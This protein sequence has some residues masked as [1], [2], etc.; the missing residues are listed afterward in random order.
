MFTDK[1]LKEF[2]PRSL[3]RIKKFCSLIYPNQIQDN[4]PNG[5]GPEIDMTHTFSYLVF[6]TLNDF[7][8]GLDGKMLER[9]DNRPIIHDI[10]VLLRR[11]A[12]L[13]YFPFLFIGRIDMALFPKAEKASR[14]ISN[15]LR[16]I[17]QE[18]TSLARKGEKINNNVFSYL[19]NTKDPET[20][21]LLSRTE[22][23]AEAVVLTMAGKYIF[24]QPWTVDSC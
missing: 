9:H 24:Q 2:E 20:G 13:L 23:K 15:Y 10:E 11:S 16:G 21:E 14:K 19:Q 22:S 1:A 17:I 6:D 18:N 7:A 8:F 4:S 12:V 3:S 5:W